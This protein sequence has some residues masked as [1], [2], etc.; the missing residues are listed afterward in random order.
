MSSPK[1]PLDSF[2]RKSCVL[3]LSSIMVFFFFQAEDGIR[4]DLVTGV[5]T[6]ALPISLASFSRFAKRSTNASRPA[7]LI[8]VAADRSNRTLRG[9]GMACQAFFKAGEE[10]RSSR[11]TIFTVKGEPDR[12]SNYS[13]L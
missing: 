6:C 13:F 10:N 11:P 2:A 4:D 7:S 5:Q 8:S 9:W 3:L 12:S 1:F